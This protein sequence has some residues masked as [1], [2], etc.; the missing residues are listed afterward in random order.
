L[1]VKEKGCQVLFRPIT[2][3]NMNKMS[4]SEIT[5][6]KWYYKPFWVW[7][8]ILSIGP[9]ALPFLILSPRFNK[10]SKWIIPIITCIVTVYF[11]YSGYQAYQ[12]INNPEELK[13]MLQ[14]YL[15]P[16]QMEMFN[17]YENMM[18]GTM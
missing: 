18:G 15:T 6:C 3:K 11:A 17:M 12:I 14:K 8:L 1:K 16:E 7:V 9:F 4:K 5:K 13:A 10:I 2:L